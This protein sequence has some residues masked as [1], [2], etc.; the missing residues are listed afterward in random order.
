MRLDEEAGDEAL[1]VLAGGQLS[2][3]VPPAL[4]EK[5]TPPDWLSRCYQAEFRR[6]ATSASAIGAADA[7]F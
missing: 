4:A 2:R 5:C 6:R 1:A 7:G 3:G